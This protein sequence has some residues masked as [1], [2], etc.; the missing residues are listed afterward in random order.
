MEQL[1]LDFRLGL[2]P[3]IRLL[4][5]LNDHVP[6]TRCYLESRDVYFAME[7]FFLFLLKEI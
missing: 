6:P 2:R 4:A 7:Y 3:K 5:D 1:R